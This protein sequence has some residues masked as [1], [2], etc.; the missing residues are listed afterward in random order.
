MEWLF[1][2]PPPIAWPIAGLAVSGLVLAATF[3][4]RRRAA[5]TA[6]SVLEVF[7]SDV[8]TIGRTLAGVV[9]APSLAAIVPIEGLGQPLWILVA[10]AAVV[11]TAALLVLRWRGQELGNAARRRPITPTG[12]PQRRLT[13]TGW[14]IGILGAG[15]TALGTYLVTVGHTFGHPIHWLVAGLG[16]FMGYAFGIGAVTPRF[17]LEQ[18]NGHQSR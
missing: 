2:D 1:S 3:V 14:E 11:L 16:L 6:G 10:V 5:R 8:A 4:A 12:A 17:R 15:G 9:A 18:P 7:W 13:S